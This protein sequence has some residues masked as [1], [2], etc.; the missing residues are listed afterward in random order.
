MTRTWH[1]LQVGKVG[2]T[3]KCFDVS[4]TS[5]DITSMFNDVIR[6]LIMFL[7]QEKKGEYVNT[8]GYYSVKKRFTLYFTTYLTSKEFIESRTLLENS[9]F[10]IFNPVINSSIC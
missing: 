8:I 4:S 9:L 6:V 2:V 1:E 10:D 5:I 3:E 7:K